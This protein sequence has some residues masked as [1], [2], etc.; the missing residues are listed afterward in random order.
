MSIVNAFLD[1]LI[2]PWNENHLAV[3]AAHEHGFSASDY[4]RWIREVLHEA[5]RV[6]P[7]LTSVE[8]REFRVGLRPATV[9]NMPIIGRAPNVDNV[10]ITTGHGRFRLVNRYL[11]SRRL[12]VKGLIH[13]SRWQNYASP[14]KHRRWKVPRIIFVNM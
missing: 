2:V 3:G 4:P 12:F 9:D 11:S 13:P 8:F 7:S 5:L 14:L 10:C 6:A 1:H